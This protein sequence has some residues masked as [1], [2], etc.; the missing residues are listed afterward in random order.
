MPSQV[1]GSTMSA[2]EK[3]DHAI[4][5]RNRSLGP[6]LGTTVSPYLD[7]TITSD[8]QKFLNLGKDALN[9]YNVL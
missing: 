2:M 3:F 7:V 1:P 6:D 5:V 9:M 4:K 8:N